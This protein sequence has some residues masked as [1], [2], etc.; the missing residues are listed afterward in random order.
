[1]LYGLAADAE[2]A[3]LATGAG[4][5]GLWTGFMATWVAGPPM[6]AACVTAVDRAAANASFNEV[7]GGLAA[8]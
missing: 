1:M 3:R 8:L 6:G 2:A 7:T 4:A 5:M